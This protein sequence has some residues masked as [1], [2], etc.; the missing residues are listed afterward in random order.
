MKLAKAYEPNNY[1]PN[2]YAMWETSGDY[3]IT[4]FT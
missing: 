4:F 3:Q 1:E 2:I